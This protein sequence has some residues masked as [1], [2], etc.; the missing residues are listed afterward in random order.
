MEHE[1]CAVLGHYATNS[2]GCA[3][4]QKTTV[5]IYSAAEA[6][7]IMGMEHFFKLLQQHVIVQWQNVYM[8]CLKTFHASEVRLCPTHTRSSTDVT[9]TPTT[10]TNDSLNMDFF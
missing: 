6:W 9:N 2:A 10:T 5:L 1:N 3:I 8:S 4:T 7:K